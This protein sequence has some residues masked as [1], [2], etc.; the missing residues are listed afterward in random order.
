MTTTC[1]LIFL[2]WWWTNSYTSAV[3][4]SWYILN[5]EFRHAAP[6]RQRAHQYSRTWDLIQDSTGV[7]KICLVDSCVTMHPVVWRSLVVQRITALSDHS[8]RAPGLCYFTFFDGEVGVRFQLPQCTLFT[9]ALSLSSFSRKKKKKKALFDK[10]TSA[11]LGQIWQH[12][13]TKY[14]G[15]LDVL[16]QLD[17]YHG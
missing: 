3:L 7:L 5:L 6:K 1:F 8:P 13:M 11:L 12:P 2:V 16:Q 15:H 9:S 4:E 17:C 10:F 14:C